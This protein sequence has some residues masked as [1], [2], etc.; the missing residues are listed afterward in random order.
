MVCCGKEGS[1]WAGSGIRLCVCVVYL[2]KGQRMGG[3][4]HEFEGNQAPKK[5]NNRC[6]CLRAG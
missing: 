5:K 1:E 4:A 3:L 6:R 2:W